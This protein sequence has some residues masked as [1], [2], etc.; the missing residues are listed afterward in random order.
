ME[1]HMKKAPEN[2]SRVELE[3]EQARLADEIAA[4][5]EQATSVKR[6]LDNKLEGERL[7]GTF[8]MDPEKLTAEDVAL[9]RAMSMKAAPD[10]RDGV[11][12][13]NL[14]TMEGSAINE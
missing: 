8:G 1:L 4:L 9:L 10:A 13:T 7:A 14:L 5:R 11:A 6:L 3:A 12:H 2:M